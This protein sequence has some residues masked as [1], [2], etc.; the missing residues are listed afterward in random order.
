MVNKVEKCG[1]LDGCLV[2]SRWWLVD[3]LAEVLMSGMF[4]VFVP[5]GP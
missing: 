3:E 1:G 4:V 5:D 2:D